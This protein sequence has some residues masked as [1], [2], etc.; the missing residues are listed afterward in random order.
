MRAGQVALITGASGGFGAACARALAADGFSLV[1]HFSRGRAAC[2]ALAGELRK[3]GTPCAVLKADLKKASACEAL[4]KGAFKAFGRLDVI[5]NNAG[6]I[7]RHASVEDLTD[8]DWRA[9]LDLNARAPYLISRAAFPKLEP[10][11]RIINISSV[12]A[13][14]GGS[15]VSP[16]YGAAK[17]ALEAVTRGLARAGAPKGILVN[18]VR[19]GVFDTPFH[20]KGKDMKGRAAMIPLKRLGT[21]EELAGTVAHLAGPRGSFITGQLIGVTGGE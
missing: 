8:K 13:R 11:A 7:E 15:P 21:A 16:H 14:F 1:L 5:V 2:A 12:A 6:A 19:A 10:G 17:A 18:A 3:A 20:G 9:A 4:V